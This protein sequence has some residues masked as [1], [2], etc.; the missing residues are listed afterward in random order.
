[1][2]YSILTRFSGHLFSIFYFLSRLKLLIIFTNKPVFIFR[3]VY[4][5]L[6]SVVSDDIALNL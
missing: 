3:L 5:R 4:E 6:K 2:S 1:M